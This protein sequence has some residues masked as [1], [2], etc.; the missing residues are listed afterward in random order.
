MN[1]VFILFHCTGRQLRCFKGM[2]LQVAWDKFLSLFAWKLKLSQLLRVR[3]YLFPCI[4]TVNNRPWFVFHVPCLG[5]FVQYT[6]TEC[7]FS[8]AVAQSRNPVSN[9]EWP[10]NLFFFYHCFTIAN[11]PFKGN[12]FFFNS[13]FGT[14]S[15]PFLRWWN[16]DKPGIMPETWFQKRKR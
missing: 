2:G 15:M 14:S 7:E 8:E 12:V 5:V 1:V 10:E 6:L 4:T 16:L 11:S 3:N 13:R 9:V